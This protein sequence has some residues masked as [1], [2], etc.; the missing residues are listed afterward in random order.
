VK[1]TLNMVAGHDDFGCFIIS[2]KNS[3]TKIHNLVNG[4]VF[5]F[6]HAASLSKFQILSRVTQSFVA[7][8]VN[9]SGSGCA[10]T[11]MSPSAL[12]LPKRIRQ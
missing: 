12:P 6:N 11:V 7:S 5:D 3:T 8:K 2:T 1:A 10:L 9:S 4:D